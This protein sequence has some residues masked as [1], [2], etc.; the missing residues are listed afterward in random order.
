MLKGRNVGEFGI[1]FCMNLAYSFCKVDV[2]EG[3]GSRVSQNVT[4][5]GPYSRVTR[6]C[7]PR[8]TSPQL[9][10]VRSSSTSSAATSISDSG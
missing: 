8:G 9:K 4:I 1:L 2:Q 10:L 3:F 7:T 5:Q 6:D